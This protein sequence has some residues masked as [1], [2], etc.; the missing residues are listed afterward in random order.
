MFGEQGN[1]NTNR[2]GEQSSS[3]TSLPPGL[4]I[5][6]TNTTTVKF[7]EI[8]NMYMKEQG[9]ISSLTTIGV[10]P[11]YISRK[12]G[13]MIYNW[14]VG[15]RIKKMYLCQYQ[16]S[17]ITIALF[18]WEKRSDSMNECGHVTTD[19]KCLKWLLDT[20]QSN[21]NIGPKRGHRT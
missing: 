13:I 7:E 15:K 1:N 3:D 8:L 12:D 6:T 18:L 9:Y 2:N 4:I 17:I 14:I 21:V 11:K 19:S 20:I 16:I 5:S 10:V